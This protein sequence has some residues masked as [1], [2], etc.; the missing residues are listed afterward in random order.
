MSCCCCLILIVL[1]GA[2]LFSIHKQ[3]VSRNSLQVYDGTNGQY[4]H[5]NCVLTNNLVGARPIGCYKCQSGGLLPPDHSCESG[6][7]SPEF[8]SSCFPGGIEPPRQRLAISC[9]KVIGADGKS[10]DV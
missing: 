10:E 7:M 8:Q 6:Y 5:V 2:A 9:I 3:K 4:F 1:I